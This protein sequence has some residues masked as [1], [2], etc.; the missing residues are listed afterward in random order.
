MFT[1]QPTAAVD[2]PAAVRHQ[3][4]SAGTGPPADWSVVMFGELPRADGVPIQSPTTASMACGDDSGY[5]SRTRRSAGT[6]QFKSFGPGQDELF[7]VTAGRGWTR[8]HPDRKDAG[9]ASNQAQGRVPGRDACAAF[10]DASRRTGSET[11]SV[12]ARRPR[13]DLW[14]TCYGESSTFDLVQVERSALL[15]PQHGH[16]AA[17]CR[18]HPLRRSPGDRSIRAPRSP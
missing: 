8:R 3:P 11:D 2:R 4:H 10:E 1:R 17:A 7:R 18:C 12:A 14:P 5:T 6:G 13:L 9:Q 16:G 15:T